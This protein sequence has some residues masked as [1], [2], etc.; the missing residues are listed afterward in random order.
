MTCRSIRPAVPRLVR[1]LRFGASLALRGAAGFAGAAA[2]AKEP[3]ATEESSAERGLLCKAASFR[4]R[5]LD[6]KAVALDGLL[7]KG[8][9]L[10][11]FW[12]TWCKPCLKELPHLQRIHEKYEAS[13]LRVL[14]V[15]IDSPKT[16]SR[17]KPFVLGKKYTFD[18]ILDS[19]QEVFR[20][21]QGKGTIPY[22]VVIDRDGN[23]RY[24]HTGYRPGDENE[25]EKVVAELLGAAAAEPSDDAPEK[26]ESSAG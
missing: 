16:E 18:V 24:R 23:I 14:A 6:G 5:D 17:V 4:A 20:A 25:I 2:S 26:I 22:V 21:L 3:V 11:D 1:R 19:S 8:P 13:G 12:A 7:G 10:V 15:T 9:V